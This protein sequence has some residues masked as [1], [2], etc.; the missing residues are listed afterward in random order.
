MI[1]MMKK[2]SSR[3]KFQPIAR[4]DTKVRKHTL[5]LF[6][7]RNLTAFGL[8]AFVSQEVLIRLA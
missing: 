1:R 6:S 5:P 7:K 8:F 4:I 2:T 3:D